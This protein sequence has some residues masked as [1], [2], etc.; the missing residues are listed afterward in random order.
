MNTH[1]SP[2][3]VYDNVLSPLQ[4]EEIVQGLNFLEPDY[5]KDDNPIMMHRHYEPGTLLIHEKIKSLI[6]FLQGYYNFK[7]FDSELPQFEFFSTGTIGKPHCENSQ[8]LNKKWVQCFRRDISYILFLTDYSDKPDMDELY[9]VYGGKLE[10]AQHGFGFNP[11]RGTLIFFPSGPHFLNATALIEKGDLFQVR[12]HL[13]AD[14]PYMYD[15]KHF[16][17]DYTKWFADQL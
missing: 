8:Y 11:Q 7:Y 17:G 9:E 16:P 6:P 14:T 1:K 10:F 4:C 15:P 3:I 12:G 2:F 13:L 5:D